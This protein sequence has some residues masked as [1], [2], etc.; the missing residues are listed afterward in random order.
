MSFILCKYD[1]TWALTSIQTPPLLHNKSSA[2]RKGPHENDQDVSHDKKGTK[3]F[4][5]SHM[6][7]ISMKLGTKQDKRQCACYSNNF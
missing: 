3:L 4:R 1:N 2:V 5:Y 6:E 7:S